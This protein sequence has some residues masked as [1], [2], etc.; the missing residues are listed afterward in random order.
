MLRAAPAFHVN[1]HVM[2]SVFY[3]CTVGEPEIA[4]QLML[5]L[6]RGGAGVQAF[7]SGIIWELAAAP[8]AAQQ[9]LDAGAVPAL[10]AVLQLTAGAA[11]YASKKKGKGAESGNSKGNP[12]KADAAAARKS[13]GAEKGGS[14]GRP[15][16][17]AAGG[18]GGTVGPPGTQPAAVLMSDPEA[19]AA[20]ALCNTTGECCC[21]PRKR[22]E[23]TSC[24]V[25]QAQRA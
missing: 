20:V 22:Y 7:V 8:T 15:G 19:A 16:S 10:L 14:K 21:W 13:S 4:A 9:L 1:L 3:C 6:G 25:L 24:W 5:L 18:T 17:A 11:G 2:H 12:N 23:V